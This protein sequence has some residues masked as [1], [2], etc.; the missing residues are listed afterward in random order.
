LPKSR[1]FESAP[2]DEIVNGELVQFYPDAENVLTRLERRGISMIL[3]KPKAST[4]KPYP[5]GGMAK[6]IDPLRDK[7]CP[8][9]T[10]TLEARRHGGMTE[11]EEVP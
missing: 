1:S 11:L 10:L 7:R 5:S 9:A 4:A 6:V 3:Q 8:P 2:L